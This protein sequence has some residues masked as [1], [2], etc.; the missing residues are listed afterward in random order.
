MSSSGF[1]ALRRKLDDLGYY[2]VYY[3]FTII[4]G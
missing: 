4:I 3:S 1:K 2:Q